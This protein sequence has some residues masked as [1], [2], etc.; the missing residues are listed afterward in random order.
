M[1]SVNKM[2]STRRNWLTVYNSDRCD[3]GCTGFQPGSSLALGILNANS[4]ADAE[5]A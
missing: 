5:N 3:G 4:F 1:L 2:T